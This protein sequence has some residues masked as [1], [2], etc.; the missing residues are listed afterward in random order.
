VTTPSRGDHTHPITQIEPSTY[1]YIGWNYPLFIAS[2]GTVL[3]TGGT[4]YL[5]KVPV[6]ISTTITNVIISLANAGVGLTAGQ[7]FAALYSGAGNL[8][9]TTAD[10]S[11]SWNSGGSK[12]M[13]LGAAQAVSAGYVYVGFFA[14]AA[15][16]L[17]GPAR[18]LANTSYANGGLS[19]A[20]SLWAT[21][22]NGTGLTT[23]MPATLGTLA[24]LNTTYWAGVS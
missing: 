9:S 14:N 24:A 8:L 17:P 11:G 21:C 19:A 16:T 3:V 10:Q 23:T 22:S 2:A 13:A 15:T 6:S 7:C 12:I 18:T 4:L 5:C 20:N 1:S